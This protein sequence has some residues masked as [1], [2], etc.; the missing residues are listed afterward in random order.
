MSLHN[1]GDKGVLDSSYENLTKIS[2]KFSDQ[3]YAD[4]TF[5]NSTSGGD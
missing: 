4:I 3:L 5:A 2:M 1:T